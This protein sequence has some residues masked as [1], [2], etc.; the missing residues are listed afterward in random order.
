MIYFMPPEIQSI[1]KSIGLDEKESA[2]YAAMLPLGS[3]A[4]R[5]IAERTGI[6][7]G[8]VHDILNS[9]SGKGL[10]SSEKYG[11]KR[12]FLVES[13]EKVLDVMRGAEQNLVSQKKKIERAMPTLMSFY[14]KQGGRPSVEYFDDDS[15]IK[16]ILDD[17][18][19][20]SEAL[21]EKIYYVYSSRSVRDYL[22]RLFPEFTKEKI[23]KGIETRVI[24]LG[25][26]GDPLN[27]K[28]AERKWLPQD[29]PSYVLVYGPKVA[30][31]SV[32]ED[33]KP[34][35]VIIRDNKISET[36]R[37]LFK[38]LWQLLK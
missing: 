38:Q 14:A 13:P 8:T 19:A 29:A 9:L 5:T 18:L 32:A 36:Q 12:R 31:I 10:V 2:V 22:Y 28:L 30:L 33:N 3:A 34:F 24:A 27:I 7:R 21:P 6:N 16:K 37:I 20:T 35:G 15:G 1:F 23:K 26:G 4:I 25:E 17:V 11:L